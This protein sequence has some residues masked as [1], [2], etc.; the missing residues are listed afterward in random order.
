M[1]HTLLHIEKEMHQ[2]FENLLWL[3]VGALIAFLATQNWVGSAVVFFILLVF[4]SFWWYEQPRVPVPASAFR[5]DTA[6]EH[7]KQLE[8]VPEDPL[9]VSVRQN[10]SSLKACRR[11]LRM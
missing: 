9:R 5:M 2:P 6:E 7:L 3:L 10:L 1:F 11:L 4:A 8:N